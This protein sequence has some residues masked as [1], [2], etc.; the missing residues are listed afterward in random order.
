MQW[1][2]KNLFSLLCLSAGLGLDA[3]GSARLFHAEGLPNGSLEFLILHGAGLLAGGIGIFRLAPESYRQN[4]ITFLLFL[5]GIQA[6]LPVLGLLLLT[7][8]IWMAS[9][10]TTKEKAKNYRMGTEWFS[11]R[12]WMPIKHRPLVH[13]Y[14]ILDILGGMNPE[15]RRNAILA[16]RNLDPRKAIPVLQKAVQDSDEQVRILAQTQFNRITGVLENRIKTLESTIAS[17]PSRT[18]LLIQLAEQYHELVYLGLSTQETIGIHLKR[19][20]DLLERALKLDPDDV[21]LLIIKLRCHLK[22]RNLG[23]AKQ[24]LE[25]LKKHHSEPELTLPWEAELYFINRQWNELIDLLINV[26]FSHKVSPVIHQMVDF[27][28]KRNPTIHE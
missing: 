7:G 1:S 9:I 3:A 4:K 15:A 16:L 19:A 11:E 13:E 25:A 12:E 8:W 28:L 24:T 27:W 5:F 17:D 22:L 18:D 20:L 10:P 2:K 23:E 21:P 14:S 26:E 6:P